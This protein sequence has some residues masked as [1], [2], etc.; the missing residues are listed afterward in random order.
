MGD[1]YIG[2]GKGRNADGTH[3]ANP[4]HKQATNR[5]SIA[6]T[7]RHSFR[8]DRME[9]QDEIVPRGGNGL[10]AKDLLGMP[11]RVAF[12]LQ[13]D[14][15]WLRSEIIWSKLNPMPESVRD[16]PT[17]SHEQV[18]L[19]AKMES[20]FYDAEAIRENDVG[21][22]HPRKIVDAP[23]RSDGFVSPDTGIRTAAGRNGFGRNKRSVWTIATEPYPDAHFA[24][25]PQ[26]LV[27]PCILAG[28]SEKGCCA[29]CGAPWVRKLKV[30]YMNP[31]NRKTNGPRS[32]G[33]KHLDYGTAGY[34]VRK[35]R[36]AKTVRWEPSCECNGKIVKKE[37]EIPKIERAAVADLFGR[38]E[39]DTQDDGKMVVTEYEPAIPLEDHPILPA[40]VLDPFMGSGTTGLVAVKAR[41]SFI[42]IDLNPDY[43]EMAMKRI[44]PELSQERLL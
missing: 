29:K 10:K 18:F 8:R 2:S 40:V 24:T 21:A 19:L 16:R 11:W 35:E 12:A 9:R 32:A 23:D 44:E 38:E 14:G 6:G 15:W 30:E 20:Y 7:I 17:K 37:I 25:F 5:G 22:D 28:T 1:A 27:E 39:A 34:D 41:R 13:A 42:G 3:N 26:K 36:T 4:N 43:A 33:R 31:G